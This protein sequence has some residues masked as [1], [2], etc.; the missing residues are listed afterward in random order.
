MKNC[1][2]KW[3]QTITRIIYSFLLLLVSV[4][5]SFSQSNEKIIKDV[6]DNIILSIGNSFPD[7]PEIKFDQKVVIAVYSPIRKTISI[8]NKIFE[9]CR[10]FKE[11]SLN[12][13]AYI[14]GHELAHHYLNHGWLDDNFEDDFQ[15]FS[16]IDHIRKFSSD[17]LKQ[18]EIET[19]ADLF[20]GFYAHLAGYNSL[21]I[22]PALLKKIYKEYN[23]K[24]NAKG[25]PTLF[26]RQV[27]VKKQLDKLKELK[28][29]FDAA[30]FALASGF[31]P[32]AQDG[33][34]YIIKKGFTSREIYNNLGISYLMEAMEKAKNKISFSYPFE[35]DAETRLSTDNS[36]DVNLDIKLSIELTK[37]C[38]KALNK[39]LILAPNYKPALINYI[40]AN[41]ILAELDSVNRK[42]YLLNAETKLNEIKDFDKNKFEVLYAINLYQNKK[43]EISLTEF[44]NCASG[45]N[46]L[47]QLNYTNLSNKKSTNM[48]TKTINKESSMNKINL[49]SILQ[50][51]S[52]LEEPYN[53]YKLENYR[54]YIK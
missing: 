50:K 28:N 40:S 49:E 8:D 45:G 52:D 4:S 22:A 9:I 13:I 24:E 51:L 16:F 21:S 36:R 33:F 6:F 41:S 47:A 43:K 29:V 23:L 1:C 30:S 10:S 46:E 37:S 7:A 5:S 12:A 32:G 42:M 35:F 44:K 19:Q 27:I 11:D 31:Y 38:V 15:G 3:N 34:D 14:L 48:E 18:L 25:Y 26:E 54:L 39:A 53:Y 2:L 17:S 20:G